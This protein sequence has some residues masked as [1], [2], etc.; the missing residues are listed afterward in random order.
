MH[1]QQGRGGADIDTR[2]PRQPL[3]RHPRDQRHG[4]AVGV[5]A[6]PTRRRLLDVLLA[7]ARGLRKSA[8]P[9]RRRPEWPAEPGIRHTPRRHARE[10]D[11]PP[12]A[13]SRARSDAADERVAGR[14][15]QLV[16]RP[17]S[18]V[19]RLEHEP[20]NADVGV[21]AR[22]LRSDRT[23]RGVM[24]TSRCGPAPHARRLP[25]PA[26]APIRTNRRQTEHGGTRPA[27]DRRSR[28]EDLVAGLVW[29]LDHV[30]E[31]DEAAV[32]IGH[33]L[34]PQHTQGGDVLVGARATIGERCAERTKFGGAITAD[35][36]QGVRTSS[37]RPPPGRCVAVRWVRGTRLSGG[38]LTPP[39]RSTRGRGGV[40]PPAD[41]RGLGA[42]AHFV[43]R[44]TWTDV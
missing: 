19:G 43:D 2:S 38:R 44:L 22:E 20:V 36:D 26:C 8:N 29:A 1:E 30:W 23:V 39:R 34:V 15:D 13:R 42:T 33:R 5:V 37:V 25:A 6:D 32:E 11:R 4:R 27:T 12:R 40:P 10:L 17:A 28:S 9:P 16:H 7:V 3:P 41:L 35:R 18:R 31:R 24:V 21:S 14:G